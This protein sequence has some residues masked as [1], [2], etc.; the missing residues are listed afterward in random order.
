MTSR[1]VS[2]MDTTS[3]LP[4]LTSAQYQALQVMKTGA[5]Y[6]Y[7]SGTARNPRYTTDGTG[8][9]VSLRVLNALVRR[10]D[11][12]TL[13]IPGDTTVYVAADVP[14]NDEETSA[15]AARAGA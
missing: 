2:D 10:G 7:T 8:T 4:S 3:P 5:A 6:R 14:D 1:S 9:G 15:R 13:R 12:T 11:A